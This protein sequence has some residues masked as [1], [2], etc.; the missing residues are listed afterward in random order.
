MWAPDSRPA[1]HPLCAEL[2]AENEVLCRENRALRQAVTD[3]EREIGDLRAEIGSFDFFA[4]CP[5]S[6]VVVCPQNQPPP[7][8][9]H[10]AQKEMP[11]RSPIMTDFS[12]EKKL[13]RNKTRHGAELREVK[14]TTRAG[15]TFHKTRDANNGGSMKRKVRAHGKSGHVSSLRRLHASGVSVLH[16][17]PG[18]PPVRKKTLAPASN[19]AFGFRKLLAKGCEFL[20]FSQQTTSMYEGFEAFSG[21]PCTFGRLGLGPKILMTP[22]VQIGG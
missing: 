11:L 6:P 19:S 4:D 2:L 21:S 14:D 10:A 13:C 16:K 18:A 3:Q 9:D 12:D 20:G 7:T 1:I 8:P 22:L 17:K 15:G 5:G